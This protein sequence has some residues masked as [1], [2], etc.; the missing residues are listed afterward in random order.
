MRGNQ[1]KPQA[2][3]YRN[4]IVEKD[5]GPLSVGPRSL[6]NQ[7]GE[8]DASALM[9]T[10]ATGCKAGFGSERIDLMVRLKLR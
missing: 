4:L 10:G 5:L 2:A 6:G 1:S 7:M 3:V 9:G 8:V